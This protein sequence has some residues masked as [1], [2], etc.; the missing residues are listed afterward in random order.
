MVLL[1][2]FIVLLAENCRI[3]FDDP[4]THLELTMIHEV[5]VLDHSGPAFGM[6]LYGA[7]LKL[8][9][10]GALVVRLAFPFST[11][12]SWLDWPALRGGDAGAR[13]GHRG[14]RIG[15]GPAA[16]DARPGPAPG[17]LSVVRFW[18]R[19]AGKVN[20]WPSFLTRC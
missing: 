12:S 6:I 18:N 16:A 1:S 11:G 13:G 5:M 9:V 7:A 15:D 3:P 14:R 10:F 20:P 8:F 2:W 19:S 17:R 4:N